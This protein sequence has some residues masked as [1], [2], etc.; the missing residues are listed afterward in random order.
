MI[1]PGDRY[2]MRVLVSSILSRT[3][4]RAHPYTRSSRTISRQLTS[5]ACKPP[6]CVTHAVA[7]GRASQ[8][9]WN[10]MGRPRSKPVVPT[11]HAPQASGALMESHQRGPPGTESVFQRACKACDVSA[12]RGRHC[13]NNCRSGPVRAYA[14]NALS[15]SS[16]NFERK[17]GSDAKRSITASN[18]ITTSSIFRTERISLAP[19]TTTESLPYSVHLHYNA[20]GEVHQIAGRG[21]A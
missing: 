8:R 7:G 11:R 4:T 18:P 13:I 6:A 20:D 19:A 10:S 9:V 2:A 5:T 16:P 14:A 17:S 15:E 1:V 3:A 21:D 12:N